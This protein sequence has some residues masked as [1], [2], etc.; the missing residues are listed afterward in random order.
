MKFSISSLYPLVLGFVIFISPFKFFV[1]L[2]EFIA[3]SNFL[4][5]L[6]NLLGYL[7]FLSIST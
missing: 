4:S 2:M 3:L 6:W 7:A 1:S 5:H